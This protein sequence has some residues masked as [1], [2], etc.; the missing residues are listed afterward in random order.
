MSVELLKTLFWQ[1]ITR[2]FKVNNK[3]KRKVY[4]FNKKL[5]KSFNIQNKEET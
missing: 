1:V 4:N 5:I 3:V 2:V